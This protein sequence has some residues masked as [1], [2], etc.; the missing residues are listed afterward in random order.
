VA[1]LLSVVGLRPEH[2]VRY[3]H[4]F[5]GGQRQRLGIA[6][7]L[8]VEPELIVCD[9]PVSALDVSVQAQVLE[10]LRSVTALGVHLLFITHDLAVVR[11]M[12]DDLV[13]L[14]HGLVVESGPT[15][16]VLEH[17]EHPYTRAL[18]AAV[19]TGRPDW[20]AA[21]GESQPVPAGR[22]AGPARDLEED[23]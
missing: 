2:A 13:V 22:P 8:A 12:T 5:S 14:E 21:G 11:Q 9:E 23:L 3:P 10:V 4:E 18:L 7:A 20:L 1:E 17:P 15:E 16:Q 19:P 6:R